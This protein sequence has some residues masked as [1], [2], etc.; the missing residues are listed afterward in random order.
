MTIISPLAVRP[1]FAAQPTRHAH[2]HG[3][4]CDHAHRQESVD[5]TW[6]PVRARRNP[7]RSLLRWTGELIRGF[8]Q[9]MKAL[10]LRRGDSGHVHG[11]DCDHS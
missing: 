11:P 4:E 8:L 5:A 2:L 10:F 9:D 3:P 7:V 1:V 6:Q